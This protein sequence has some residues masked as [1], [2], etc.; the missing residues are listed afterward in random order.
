MTVELPTEP[1][2]GE[3]YWLSEEQL[4]ANWPSLAGETYRSCLWCGGVKR[5]DGQPNK[6]CRGRVKVG[7]R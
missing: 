4:L 3:H 7:L 2:P 6:P 1:I 5:E